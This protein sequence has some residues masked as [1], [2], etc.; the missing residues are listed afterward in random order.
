MS[1]TTLALVG[2]S[3]AF[4]AMTQSA[5]GFGFSLVFVPIVSVLAGP[6]VAVVAASTLGPLLTL[7]VAITERR[8]IRREMVLLLAGAGVLGM[9]L[10]LWV[11]THVAGRTLELIIG[12]VVIAL[13]TALF[14]GVTLPDRWTVDTVAG[15]ASGVLATSTGTNG[16]PVVLALQ[17]R[18]IP[19]R[20]MR[21][22]LSAV[23]LLQAG[24]ALV[25]F[26]A[27]GQVTARV[28]EVVAVG[29]P[30]LI[31]GRLM[32]DRVFGRLDER[33]YGGVVLILL[34]LAGALALIEAAIR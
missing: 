22:T 11:L 19:P 30:G 5:S 18:R 20:E 2:L 28:G 17:A 14:F 16:P 26:A 10:G 9:P 6:K 27:T 21:A 32:G 4:A 25:A 12:A 23:F 1:E 34:F 7:S 29:L 24:L 31:L 3:V 8:H 15:L 33:R 13:T